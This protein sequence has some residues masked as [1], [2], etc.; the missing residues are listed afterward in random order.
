M[1]PFLLLLLQAGINI[2]NGHLKNAAGGQILDLS[3]FILDAAKALDSLHEEETGQP[4]DW[5][6][7]RE[8]QPLAPPGSPG[9]PEPSATESPEA[10]ESEDPSLENPADET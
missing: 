2:A 4:L 9:E 5:S 6:K 8:H 10:P 3:S 1:N 7:I